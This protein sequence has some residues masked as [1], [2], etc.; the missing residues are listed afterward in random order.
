MNSYESE[1]K[2]VDNIQKFLEEN[3]CKTWREVIPDGCKNW[4]KPWRV[5]LVFYRDDFG[6]I[7]VEAKNSNTLGSGGKMAQA[8]K[9]VLDKYKNQTYFKGNIIER[10]CVLV[11]NNCGWKP[12]ENEQAGLI[13]KDRI[14][15]FIRNFLKKMFDISILEYNPETKWMKGYITIDKLTKNSIKIG[16]ESKWKN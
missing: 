15:C 1:E 4:N 5:D 10:W 8:V 6:F 11:P 14:L 13:A 9:Q 16:G 12:I 3:G 7:G 2:F